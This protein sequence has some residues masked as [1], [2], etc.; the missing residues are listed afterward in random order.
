MAQRLQ[1]PRTAAINEKIG[2]RYRF[3]RK[4]NTDMSS[5]E[6]AKAL[7]VSPGF[8]SMVE[9]GKRGMKK[10]LVPKAAELL[11]CSPIVLNDPRELS[12][13]QL[14]LYNPDD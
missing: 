6:L 4:L 14:I 12:E 9:R 13:R 7:G 8:M 10:A 2:P 1:D 11:K 3:F 5:K